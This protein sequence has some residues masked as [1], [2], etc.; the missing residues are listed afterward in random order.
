MRLEKTNSGY[1]C[2]SDTR[3]KFYGPLTPSYWFGGRW[4]IRLYRNRYCYVFKTLREAKSWARQHWNPWFFR[5]CLLDRVVQ[6][7]PT[8]EALLAAS[9]QGD[10]VALSALLDRAEERGFLHPSLREEII[11]KARRAGMFRAPDGRQAHVVH[12]RFTFCGGILP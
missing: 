5:W 10:E 4:L 1:I 12:N 7:D 9:L 3:L 11:R 8:A 6:G 2:A